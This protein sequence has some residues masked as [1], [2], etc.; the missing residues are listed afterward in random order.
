MIRER[1]ALRKGRL[2]PVRILVRAR[3]CFRRISALLGVGVF[4]VAVMMFARETPE[5]AQAAAI[6]SVSPSRGSIAGGTTVTLNASQF[7][8]AWRAAGYEMV[9]YLTF[10]GS[11]YINTGVNQIGDTKVELDFQ[12]TTLVDP[13]ISLFGSRNG[14]WNNSSFSLAKLGSNDA[15]GVNSRN[16]FCARYGT[17]STA[18]T[19]N[20]SVSV[21]PQFRDTLRHKWVQDNG[22][23]WWSTDGGALAQPTQPTGSRTAPGTGY[24]MFVGAINNSGSPFYSDGTPTHNTRVYSLKIWKTSSLTRDFIPVR[25][26]STNAYGLWDKQNSVFYP[27][28]A[29]TLSGGPDILLNFSVD[30][31]GAPCNITSVTG[32]QITCTTTT[33]TAGSANVTVSESLTGET[34]NLSSGYEYALDVTNISPVIG[35][36]GGG[37]T[38]T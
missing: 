8:P 29:G 17:T 16:Y 31:G 27:A 26:L 13:N 37:Q 5:P 19:P 23:T 28:T 18:E 14:A 15:G 4:G 3:G 6:T 1:S 10:T 34:W 7:F 22:T 35:Q 12:M 33:H 25:N 21:Y 11:Q 32:T 36:T 20:R 9:E 24:S 2:R 38:V 30:I